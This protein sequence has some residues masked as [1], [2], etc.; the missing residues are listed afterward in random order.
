MKINAYLRLT[1]LFAPTPRLIGASYNGKLICGGI[2]L[3][4]KIYNHLFKLLETFC[5][6]KIENVFDDAILVDLKTT[7][8][9][10]IPILFVT[11]KLPKEQD[12]EEE[13]FN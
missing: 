6:K 9:R 1:H 13:V 2:A 7:T 11:T 12:E 3:F 10:S 4:F 5:L 8:V